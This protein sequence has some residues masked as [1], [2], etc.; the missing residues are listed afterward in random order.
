MPEIADDIL[1][2][3][4][5]QE[6][7][8]AYNLLYQSYFNSIANYIRQNNGSEQ[9]AEDIFQEAILILLSKARQPNF[10]LTA[11][12]K[13]YLF[14]ISKNLWLKKIRTDKRMEVQP[15]TGDVDIIDLDEQP[16]QN[17]KEEKIIAW[18]QKITANCQRILRSIFFLNEP[19]DRLMVKMGWKNKH[20]AANQKYK[21]L[22]QIRK[23]SEK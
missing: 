15:P 13:T 3:K 22:K 23:E 11:S 2:Q 9:D 18:L 17:I 6:E 4:L 16:V 7:N 8:A 1:L 20:T 5:R 10:V 21:C 19:M 12:L 14:S